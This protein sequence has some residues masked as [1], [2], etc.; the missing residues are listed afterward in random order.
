M[1]QVS[2]V[3]HIRQLLTAR[4]AAAAGIMC[5][6]TAAGAQQAPEAPGV[7]DSGAIALEEIVVT[8]QK[9]SE[10]LNDVPISIAALSETRL[11]QLGAKDLEGFAREVPGLSVQPA[12]NGGAPAISIRGISS[13][14]G[15]ATVGVYIDDTP[16]QMPNS[17]FAA[18]PLPKLFDIERVEVLRGPQGTLYGASSEGGTI[19]YI[20]PVASLT[21]F[22]GR[23]HSEI[24]FT[25]GGSPSYEV[26]AALGG[27]VVDDVLGLRGSL[28]YRGDGG[29]IDQVS[30]VTGDVLAHNVNH[31]DALSLR[32][33]ANLV[34]TDGLQILPAVYYQRDQTHAL[35]L[36]YS[37]LGVFQ[38]ANTSPTPGEDRFVLPSLTINYDMGPVRLTSV[39]SYFDRRDTQQFDYSLIT[40]DT[41]SS[42]IA[43]QIPGFPVMPIWPTDPGY[44]SV[45]LTRTTERNFTQEIRLAS[46]PDQGPFSYT[47]GAFYQHAHTGFDQQVVEPDMPGL[48]T[49]MLPGTPYTYLDLTGGIPLLPGGLSYEQTSWAL[50]EQIAGFGELSYNLTSALKVTAGARVANIKVSSQFDANGIYNLGPTP[51]ALT[52]VQHSSQTPVDPKGTVSYQFNTDNL[53]YATASRGF[54]AGGP[55]TPVPV[56][57]CEADLAAAG[58]SAGQLANFKSDSVWNYELGAKTLFADRRVSLN[59]SV[60]YIDWTSIQQALSLPT[61]GFGYV[62]NLGKATS[63]GFDLEG[64][65]ILLEGLTLEAA[66]GYTH[67]T[68]DGNVYGGLDASTGQRELVA[69][70]GDPTLLSPE[71]TSN[72]ALNYERAIASGYRGYGRADL[73]HSGGF[74]RIESAGTT[75]Y[76]ADLYR[77]PAYNTVSLRTG[78]THAGWNFALFVNNLTNTQPVL[79]KSYEFDSASKAIASE[80]TLR[81]RTFGIDA[82]YRF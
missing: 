36:G 49:Q 58:T 79:F 45:S 4:T 62:A 33:S 11:E 13:A 42:G 19:R 23:A 5:I 54:R 70:D 34:P 77:G 46:A 43:S 52:Q 41:F 32:L 59:G 1:K 72:F 78:V 50:E 64:Q 15:D 71:W 44:Q 63:R 17:S 8:A 14:A 55:N 6:S 18:D 25:D 9:R 65:F 29:Y 39:S 20:T 48:V 57:R 40:V 69:R 12:T 27:P 38:E 74:N 7:D 2:L 53:V 35:S 26:G 75:S 47:V 3:R 51:A 73:Q 10:K 31:S 68:L 66:A 76:I 16:V 80:S 22:S 82:D 37:T 21:E 56:G 81:P 28:Y 24:A 67:S 61:C 60:F 30:R